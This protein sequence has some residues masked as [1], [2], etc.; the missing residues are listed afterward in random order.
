V[1]GRF[2]ESLVKKLRSMAVLKPGEEELF[3]PGDVTIK[4]ILEAIASGQVSPVKEEKLDIK[5]VTKAVDKLRAMRSQ[6]QKEG[7]ILMEEK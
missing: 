4:S 3:K 1:L 5:K 7:D 2:S 6:P